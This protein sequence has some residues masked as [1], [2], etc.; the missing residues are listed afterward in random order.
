MS[1]PEWL[2]AAIEMRT[3]VPRR[4]WREIHAELGVPE[5]QLKFWVNPRLR[6]KAERKNTIT[7][8]HKTT[9]RTEKLRQKRRFKKGDLSTICRNPKC[10]RPTAP[11]DPHHVVYE[12]HVKN[13]GGDIFDPWN[14]LRLCRRCHERHHDR[15]PALPLTILRQNNIDFAAVL[16][17]AARAYE[18]LTRRYSGS[19]DRVDRLIEEAA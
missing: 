9:N 16:L 12:Q 17:G 13:E 18:Y 7:L 11:W 15:N 6:P 10:E 3:Q 1:E 4:S 8:A 14:C 5:S 19:D 2:P